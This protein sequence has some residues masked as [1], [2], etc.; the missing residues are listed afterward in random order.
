MTTIVTAFNKG[1]L[2]LPIGIYKQAKA[3]L[4]EVLGIRDRHSFFD[5]RHEKRPIDVVKM[6]AVQQVFSRYGIIDIWGN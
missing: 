2:Q 3:E 4:Y 1:Y 6:M 5:Y